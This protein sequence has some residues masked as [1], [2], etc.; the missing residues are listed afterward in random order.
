MK[1]SMNI[2]FED[3]T[4]Q[5]SVVGEGRETLSPDLTIRILDITFQW[6]FRKKNWGLEIPW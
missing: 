3:C 2:Y 1:K 5:L 4:L 6:M